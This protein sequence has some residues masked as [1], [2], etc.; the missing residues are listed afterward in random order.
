MRVKIGVQEIKTFFQRKKEILE[1][2]VVA[3]RKTFFQPHVLYEKGSTQ[4]SETLTGD[5]LQRK[6]HI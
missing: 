3:G 5:S 2:D 4:S 1:G 6:I